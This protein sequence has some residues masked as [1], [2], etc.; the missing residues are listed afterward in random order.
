MLVAL[1]GLAGCS[2]NNAAT[3][4]GTVELPATQNTA[5]STEAATT[6][7]VTTTEAA[8]EPETTIVLEEAAGESQVGDNTLDTFMRNA[9]DHSIWSDPSMMTG[10]AAPDALFDTLNA[11]Q[12]QFY[13]LFY[14][15]DIASAEA[16]F[17]DH[18]ECLEDGYAHVLI[19]ESSLR[20]N[21]T[22]ICTKLGEQVL[23]IDADNQILIMEV[24]CDGSRGVLAVGKHPSSLRLCPSSELP[25]CGET[26]GT[27]AEDNG[28]VLAI[29]GSGFLDEGGVGNG[30]QIAG[31]ALCSN[32]ESYGCHYGSG[33][34]RIE[35]HENGWLYIKDAF[36]PEGEGTVAG[37]EFTP[38]LLINGKRL[39]PGIWTSQNPRACI[40][41]SDH[42]EILMLCVE[43]RTKASPGCSVE[44]CSDV[45]LQHGGITALN[46]DGGTTAILWYR[47]EP[48]IRCSNAAIPQGR[49][50][51]NAWVYVGD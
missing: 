29:T 2:G 8:S 38:G 23:A 30:S 3:D 40:G 5:V 49:Y 13:S 1:L 20:S 16:W 26:I 50:L 7:Q 18:P 10:L 48:L 47:G 44:V 37:M 27:I 31:W 22:T 11:E 34:K 21:G 15:L 36:D 17:R 46:C 32:G 12:K 41:Q 9:D 33:Y 39:D 24:D 19:N 35:L 51:P 45:L 42:G 43:G 28:G 4:I 25:R 6:V 14:E